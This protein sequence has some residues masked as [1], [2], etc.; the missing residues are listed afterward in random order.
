MISQLR[1]TQTLLFSVGNSAEE[2]VERHILKCLQKKV[3]QN[4]FPRMLFFYGQN[5]QSIRTAS[6]YIYELTII[7]SEP[8]SP[9]MSGTY[10]NTEIIIRE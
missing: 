1:L 2:S 3:P 10:C 7:T 6:S 5:Q 8:L 4:K 9:T